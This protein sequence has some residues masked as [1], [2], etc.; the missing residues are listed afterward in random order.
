MDIAALGYAYE[1]PLSVMSIDI[2]RTPFTA[3]RSPFWAD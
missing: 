3:E 1:A 2:I